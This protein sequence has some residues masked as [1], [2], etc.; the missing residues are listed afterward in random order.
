MGVRPVGGPR[1]FCCAPGQALPPPPP[2]LGPHPVGAWMVAFTRQAPTLR[3]PFS[4]FPGARNKAKA[5]VPH[6]QESRDN[7]PA[8][9]SHARSHSDTGQNESPADNSMPHD[10]E[11]FGFAND[12]STFPV[13][14]YASCRSLTGLDPRTP[15]LKCQPDG[16]RPSWPQ[17]LLRFPPTVSPKQGLASG[18]YALRS[19]KGTAGKGSALNLKEQDNGLRQKQ[20]EESAAT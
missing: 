9:H 8:V 2:F 19:R 20:R 6:P 3:S 17:A 4:L 18:P 13:L 14:P 1:I 11:A 10:F 16:T 5:A 15:A 12:C 7:V